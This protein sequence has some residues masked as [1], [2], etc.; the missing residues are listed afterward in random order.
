[1]KFVKSQATGN[2]FV[3]IDARKMPAKNWPAM[4]VS[5]CDRRFG[6]GA[7]GV[8]LVV[9]SSTADIAMRIFNADGSEAETCGNGLRCLAKYVVDRQIV[10]TRKFKISTLSGIRN[11]ETF[12][13]EGKVHR[14]RV[15]M[16]VPSFRPGDIPYRTGSKTS[17]SPSAP[18]VCK[19]SVP[20]TDLTVCLASMGNPHAVT[21]INTPVS[22]YPLSAIG[23]QVEHYPAFAKRIN[24]EV[25]KVKDSRTIEARV[26]ERG[27]GETLSCG[28]GACAIAAVSRAQGLVGDAV[29]II[30][31]GGTVTISWDKTGNTLLAGP[32]AEVFLGEWPE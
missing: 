22:E 8:I 29:D 21:Y 6:I 9:N 32:V 1:M 18:V 15:S 10:R 2:D 11:A 31:P 27:V 16:G 7:D 19:V 24:F 25:V 28:S 5:M 12:S 23:P 26:W 20:G 17:A 30:I 3:M 13:K 4:A 14:V